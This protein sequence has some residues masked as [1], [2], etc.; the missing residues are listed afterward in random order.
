MH[1]VTVT[2]GR[3]GEL[4]LLLLLLL[5]RVYTAVRRSTGGVGKNTIIRTA[6]SR[7]TKVVA[8]GAMVGCCCVTAFFP[9]AT[10]R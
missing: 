3:G 8:G 7:R 5:L 4:L 10:R 6:W 1:T 2:R 9:R